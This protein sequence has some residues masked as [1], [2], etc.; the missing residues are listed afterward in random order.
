[1][2]ILYLF[3]YASLCRSGHLDGHVIFLQRL[4]VELEIKESR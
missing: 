1:M 4:R 2:A 3:R